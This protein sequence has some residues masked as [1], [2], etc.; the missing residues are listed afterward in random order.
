MHD[1][2]A[3]TF[4]R[5][6][7]LAGLLTFGASFFYPFINSQGAALA[8]RSLLEPAP[9]N[10]ANSDRTCQ[11]I[12]SASPFI[13]TELFFGS[14]KPNG[15]EVNDLEFQKFINNEVTPRFP[16]GLTILFG[17][18]QFKNSRGTIVKENSRLLVLLYPID[19][20]D[21]SSQKIEQ[22]RKIYKCKFQQESVLRSDN[23]SCVSF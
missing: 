12:P 14:L 9:T 23:R 22:I 19:R 2:S 11:S 1:K 17:L 13:R 8:Q 21:D 16:D 10:E 7:I 20:Q 18:G 15:S 4:P 5:N 6:L 3:P